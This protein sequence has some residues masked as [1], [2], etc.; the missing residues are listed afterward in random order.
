VVTTSDGV[1]TYSHYATPGDRQIQDNA[2]LLAGYN[3]GIIT[4]TLKK[5]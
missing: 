1:R 5:S 4:M 2:V 3:L